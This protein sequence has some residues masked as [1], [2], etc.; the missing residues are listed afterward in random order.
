MALDIPSTAVNANHQISLTAAQTATLLDQSQ[1]PSGTPSVLFYNYLVSG[2]AV[3]GAQRVQIF[4]GRIKVTANLQAADA[5]FD[6]RTQERRTL[7]NINAVLEGRAT[8]T[9]L[10]SEV[11]GTRL[12][13]IPFADL[14]NLQAVY[15]VKVRN[16]EIELKQS[17]G[18]PTGKTLF[19]S[20][21]RPRFDDYTGQL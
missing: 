2:Y 4:S 11:E 9:I 17:Q 15:Q 13:R 8:S 5:G 20:F 12:E 1:L 7:D 18:Q 16:Q 3:N 21:T 10:K 19:A 14:L 6:P